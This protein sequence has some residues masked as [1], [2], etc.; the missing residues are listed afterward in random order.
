[1]EFCPSALYTARVAVWLLAPWGGA[2]TIWP[3]WSDP[4]KGARTA[5][6]TPSKNTRLSEPMLLPVTVTVPS[7]FWLTA[8]MD[9]GCFCTK[10]TAE[11]ST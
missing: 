9:G 10:F 11:G 1:M 6:C 3:N 8:A 2:T 4:A 5:A 7:G